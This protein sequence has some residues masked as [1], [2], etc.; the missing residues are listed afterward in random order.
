MSDYIEFC[1]NNGRDISYSNL[2]DNKKEYD[3]FTNWFEKQI[4]PFYIMKHSDDL[5]SVSLSNDDFWY[6]WIEE[7]KIISN[8]YGD[9]YCYED[10]FKNYLE[11]NFNYLHKR[12]KYDS[13]NG[14]FCLYCNNIEDAEEICYELSNLYNDEQKMINLIKHIKYKYNYNFDINI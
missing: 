11:D 4:K 14:M 10:A 5:F 1:N 3:K 6:D 12:V 13:E 7:R 9:G 2:I 8:H